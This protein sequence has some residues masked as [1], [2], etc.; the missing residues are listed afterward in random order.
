MEYIGKG[1]I[2]S[3][4]SE[5]YHF[6]LT[7]NKIGTTSPVAKVQKDIIELFEE[8]TS[9]DG[10]TTLFAKGSNR[11]DEQNNDIS[12]DTIS[13]KISQNLKFTNYS[14]QSGTG[15]YGVF[16]I[17]NGA[18]ERYQIEDA[19]KAFRNDKP[20]DLRLL[21]TFATQLVFSNSQ[22]LKIVCLK[23]KLNGISDISQQTMDTFNKIKADVK[24]SLI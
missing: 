22:N 21:R 24:K 6:Y 15:S 1:L 3:G 10:Q 19:Q 12:G 14:Y 23:N 13:S 17:Q 4:D 16:F 20:C 8:G 2:K 11:L 7:D 5:L 9:S 18:V